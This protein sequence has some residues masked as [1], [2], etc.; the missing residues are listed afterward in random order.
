MDSL[1]KLGAEMYKQ[2]PPPTEEKPEEKSEEKTDAKKA[3]EGE[4]VN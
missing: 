1:Q 4:V 3:E 2:T